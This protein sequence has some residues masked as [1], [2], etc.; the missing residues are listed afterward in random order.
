MI[1]ARRVGAVWGVSGIVCL[2]GWAMYR[3]Y[4]HVEMAV[5]GGLTPAQWALL[6]L[7]IVFMVI[8]EGRDGF[9]RRLAPRIATRSAHIYQRGDW[10]EVI[11]A[12]LYCFG[13][14]RAPKKQLI[15]SYGAVVVIICVVVI[16]HQFSQPWRGIVDSGVIVGL[17]YGIGA[18]M[19]HVYGKIITHN[20][21]PW[22]TK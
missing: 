13:Y 15:V 11:L 4:P 10:L 21:D 7:W 3:L 12:P 18:I 6:L 9:Q 16:V 19:L 8:S 1:L 17:L 2:L 22:Y 5:V 20:K 14:F